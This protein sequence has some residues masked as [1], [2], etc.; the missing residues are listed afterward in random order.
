[1]ACGKL[2]KLPYYPALWLWPRGGGHPTSWAGQLVHLVPH[3]QHQPTLL[4]THTLLMAQGYHHTGAACGQAR[5][6]PARAWCSTTWLP[7]IGKGRAVWCHATTQGARGARQPVHWGKWFGK[8][9]VGHH[10]PAAAVVGRA[11][12]SLWAG[13]GLTHLQAGMVGKAEPP[14]AGASGLLVVA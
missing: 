6:A 8:P 11:W 14:C 10:P 9:L 2:P 1:M 13:H 4:P 7:G 3:P 12:Q 5:G